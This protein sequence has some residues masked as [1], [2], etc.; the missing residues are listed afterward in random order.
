ML[1]VILGFKNCHSGLAGIFPKKRPF[2]TPF[3]EGNEKDSRQAGMTT[4][5]Q[6]LP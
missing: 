5:E 6:G 1:N 4:L 3:L 2:H